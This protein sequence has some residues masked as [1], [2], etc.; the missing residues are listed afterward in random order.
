MFGS[1]VG[2]WVWGF[3]PSFGSWGIG[4]KVRGSRFRLQTCRVTAVL[5]VSRNPNAVW[6][7][8]GNGGMGCR[9]YY[10]GPYGTII[11]IHSPIPYISTRQNAKVEPP[12]RRH[13]RQR[14]S[15]CGHGGKRTS[16]DGRAIH[17]SG[18]PSS[19]AYETSA[20]MQKAD[21]KP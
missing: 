15:R 11:G 1:E 17:G 9:D 3:G 19:E 12:P 8:V 20:L 6:C 5:H 13:R 2:F 16:H 21:P 4:F 14:C 7:L 10:K 18:V